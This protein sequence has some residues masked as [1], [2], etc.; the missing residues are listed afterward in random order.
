VGD[1]GEKTV[2]VRVDGRRGGGWDGR[3]GKLGGIRSRRRP[4]GEKNSAKKLQGQKRDEEK[5]SGS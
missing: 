5:G 4:G 1:G 2:D 3:D